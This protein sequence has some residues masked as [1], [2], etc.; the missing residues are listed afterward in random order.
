MGGESFVLITLRNV[1]KYNVSITNKVLA[2]SET[3]RI[4][5]DKLSELDTLISRGILRIESRSHRKRTGVTIEGNGVDGVDSY[6]GEVGERIME[7]FFAYHLQR[8]L[9]ESQLN[10]MIWFYRNVGPTSELNEEVKA[11]L[12]DVTDVEELVTVLLNHL[13]PALIQRYLGKAN[14]INP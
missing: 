8:E 9:T 5:D 10:D 13:Y 12:N 1:S 14:V 3:I 11:L 6:P 7:A 2:P 4:D